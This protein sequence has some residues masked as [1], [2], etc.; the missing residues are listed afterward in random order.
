[1]F[2]T[3]NCY[4]ESL[5]VLLRPHRGKVRSL[6][7]ND[8]VS[9]ENVTEKVNSRCLKLY[10]VSSMSFDSSNAGKFF[11]ELNSKGLYQNSAKEKESCCLVFPSLTKYEIRHFHVIVVERR[12]RN[13]Q[14]SVM[15]VQIC[16][17][18]NINLLLFSRSRCRRFRR[19]LSSLIV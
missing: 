3:R 4:C 17:F 14:K 7:N 11:S 13:V 10:C 12:Q 18:A 6:S 8:G 19:C 15:H 16:C 2:I 5:F 9:Y 1:M